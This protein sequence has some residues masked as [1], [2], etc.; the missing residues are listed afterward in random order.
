MDN[1]IRFEG[2]KLI[3]DVNIFSDR[4]EKSS[5]RIYSKN[6]N[7]KYDKHSF[8]IDELPEKAFDLG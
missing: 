3:P 2:E 1:D 7:T 4:K 6:Y 8:R 5:N